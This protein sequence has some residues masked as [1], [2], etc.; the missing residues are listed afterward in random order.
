MEGTV[1][2]SEFNSD[3]GYYI[4]VRPGEKKTLMARV[5][6]TRDEALFT[7]ELGVKTFRMRGKWKKKGT[8]ND[9]DDGDEENGK[10]IG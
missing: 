2:G 6:L 4:L 7:F 3:Q 1:C 8:D 5:R 9:D 10:E